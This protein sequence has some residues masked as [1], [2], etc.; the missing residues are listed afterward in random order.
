MAV[1]ASL[2]TASGCDCRSH[3][4]SSGGQMGGGG[5]R[6][7]PVGT[8]QRCSAQPPAGTGVGPQTSTGTGQYQAGKLPHRSL[9]I[10]Y[11]GSLGSTDLHWSSSLWERRKGR[12]SAAAGRPPAQPAGRVAWHARCASGEPR[13]RHTPAAHSPSTRATPHTP[14]VHEVSVAGQPHRLLHSRGGVEG[15]TALRGLLGH[16]HSALGAAQGMGGWAGGRG[17]GWGVVQRAWGEGRTVL[18]RPRKRRRGPA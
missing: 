1:C 18:Q 11:G 10:T 14:G 4:P 17:V 3:R 6:M 7:Q 15:C 12:W 2:P 9:G 5:G 8:S 16:L 13:L